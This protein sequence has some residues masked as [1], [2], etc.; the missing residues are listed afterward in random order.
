M[1]EEL[2]EWSLLADVVDTLLLDVDDSASSTLA[3]LEDG[4]SL[5]PAL[6]QLGDEQLRGT[7]FP[8]NVGSLVLVDIPE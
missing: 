6:D 5:L 4:W 2:D 3:E 7:L 1:L 8:D